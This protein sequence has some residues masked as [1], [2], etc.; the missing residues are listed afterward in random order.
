MKKLLFIT[1]LLVTY[2][3]TA[4]KKGKLS[5]EQ[6]IEI[7]YKISNFDSI[8]A[9]SFADKI[10]TSAKTEYKFIELKIVKQ[11]SN[12]SKDRTFVYRY[13]PVNL[14]PDDFEK[15]GEYDCNYSCMDVEF[16]VVYDGANEDLEEKGTKRLVFHLVTGKFL[17]IFPTWEREFLSTA[18][19]EK[20]LDY[21]DRYVGNKKHDGIVDVRIDKINGMWQIYNWRYS[22]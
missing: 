21:E 9:R 6:Y 14:Y 3:T 1:L 16:N 20:V 5:K 18:T 19:K 11:S 12:K 8:T 17:D 22:D 10:A 4:Q 15:T 7:N 13:I 2:V